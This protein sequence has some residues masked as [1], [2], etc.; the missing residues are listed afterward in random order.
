MNFLLFQWLKVL[1]LLAVVGIGECGK[2]VRVPF[3]NCY[4]D[5]ESPETIYNFTMPDLWGKRNIS[6]SDYEGKQE[7]GANATEIWNGIKYVRPG[8][9]FEPNF[10]LFAK[11]EAN[12]ETEAPLYTYLKKMCPSTRD[13]HGETKN[14][15]YFPLKST[16]LRWNFEKFL[17]DR[18]GRP[19]RRFDPTFNP[20][21][22]ISHV[23]ELL[24][25]PPIAPGR[26][27]LQDCTF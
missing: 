9:G 24:A 26:R 8:H 17:I 25:A 16:D 13:G 1:G 23:T 4:I 3:K 10:Q 27:P 19:W 14:L 2:V 21:D 20:M 15:H 12:G 6:L 22:M 7:Q 11:I 5:H 18:S